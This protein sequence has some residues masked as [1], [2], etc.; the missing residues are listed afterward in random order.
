MTTDTLIENFH[1]IATAPNGITKL[2]E[3]ILHLAIRGRIVKAESKYEPPSELLERFKREKRRRIAAHDFNT[4]AFEPRP[5]L[6][7]TSQLPASW[8]QCQLADVCELKTGATPSRSVGRYFGGDIKWLVSGD[9]NQREIFD[10]EGRITDE[11]IENS[12][13]KILPANCV[14]IALNGQGKTRA[15]VAILRTPAACN[16]SLV[17]MIP[18]LPDLM[19]EYLFWNLRSKYYSIREITGQKQ[20]RGLNMKLVGSLALE[21][22]SFPEQKRIVAKVNELMALCDALEAKFIQSHTDADTLA[23][24]IIHHL[25]YGNTRSKGGTA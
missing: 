20:R 8:A 16:Q 10:C 23:A 5:I 6:P 24:A 17:A 22:P 11:G 12:N 13:C 18:I 9:V 4:S 19:P 25:C 3:L 7:P 1:L 21:L 2:R 14:L 15:T